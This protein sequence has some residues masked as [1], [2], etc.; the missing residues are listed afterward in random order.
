MNARNSACPANTAFLGL[1]PQSAS[2]WH[3]ISF[4][5]HRPTP[6]VL[7]QLPQ[8]IAN[9]FKQFIR[10]SG[11]T[12]SRTSPYYPQSN[13]KIERWHKSLKGEC[14]PPETPPSLARTCAASGGELRRA[15]RPAKGRHRIYLRR[16]PRW[17]VAG[18]HSDRKQQERH[19]QKH[20]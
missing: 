2:A 17:K 18:Q 14:I 9:D 5:A 1:F 13:G 16:P 11:M 19:G 7:P 10:I 15:L 4:E 3:L 12:H 8:F 6:I 20:K